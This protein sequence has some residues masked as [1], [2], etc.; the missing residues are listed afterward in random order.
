MA[1]HF[2]EPPDAV[3]AATRRLPGEER[4]SLFSGPREEVGGAP[5]SLAQP[6]F[7]APPL[8]RRGFCRWR[9]ARRG[10]REFRP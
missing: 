3:I 4:F 2:P 7:T 8:S 6:A 5:A 1:I 10:P 9:Q